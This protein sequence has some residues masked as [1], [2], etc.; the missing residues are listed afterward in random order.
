MSLLNNAAWRYVLPRESLIVNVWLVSPPRTAS[1]RKL[2]AVFEAENAADVEVVMPP[3]RSTCCTSEMAPDATA[4][5][6]HVKVCVDDSDPSEAVAVTFQVPADVGTFPEINPA[7]L[8][9]NPVG[10][11]DA[12]YVSAVPFGSVAESCNETVA[13]EAL[14]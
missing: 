1:T 13:P 6:V 11:P 10:R 5:T 9:D 2:P 12:E 14:V 8:I 3:S 7:L 4:V